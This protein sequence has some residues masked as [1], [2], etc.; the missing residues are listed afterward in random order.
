LVAIRLR[1]AATRLIETTDRVLEIAYDVGFGDV[2]HFNQA[3]AAAFSTTPTRF[4]R[5]HGYAPAPSRG[6][7]ISA[8]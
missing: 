1:A 6:R 7:L 5:R 2:S 8:G 3:F 4:R